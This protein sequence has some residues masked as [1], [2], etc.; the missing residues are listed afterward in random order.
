LANGHARAGNRAEALRILEK[1]LERGQRET[2]HFFAVALISEGLPDTE[3]ALPWLEK[4]CVARG[5]LPVLLTGDPTRDAL[6]GE[7]RFQEI[8]RR[9][10]LAS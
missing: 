9:M 5:M 1:L 4:A 8:S 2:I 3:N 6:R 10:K 7:P